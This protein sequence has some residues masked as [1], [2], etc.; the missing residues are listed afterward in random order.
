MATSVERA[1][2]GPLTSTSE[3]LLQYP[4]W[5]IFQHSQVNLREEARPGK[6]ILHLSAKKVALEL[7][8]C[9]TDFCS[10]LSA[11]LSRLVRKKDSSS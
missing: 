8:N 11:R 6:A 10:G 9:T 3:A 5:T 7:S 2:G 4:P 1:K